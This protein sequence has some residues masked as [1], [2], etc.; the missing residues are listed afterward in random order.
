[1]PE[2]K[3]PSV[4]LAERRGLTMIQIA[5]IGG[6]ADAVRT[7]AAN[8]G[9]VLPA[10]PNTTESRNGVAAL[11]LG[12]SRWLAVMSE[13]EPAALGRRLEAAVA[14][15]AAIC[16]VS[17]ARTVFRVSGPAIRALLAKGCR[18]DLHPRVF[19]TGACAQTNIGHFT[20]LLH[21]VDDNP[22]V[23]LYVARSYAASFW[24]WLTE[25]AAEFGYR[26][27]ASLS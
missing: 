17:H 12:P 8:A 2:L 13:T 19:H 3:S 11:W 26:V 18:L 27:A 7:T 24:E 14:D 9:V 4:V 23:D 1:M 15:S 16:D 20:V 22:T 10:A 21:G 6:N 5:A 25:A